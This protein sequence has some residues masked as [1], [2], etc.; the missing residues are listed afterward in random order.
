MG[1]GTWYVQSFSWHYRLFVMLVQRI[2][3][4]FQNTRETISQIAISAE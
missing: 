4:L 1:Q 3:G 2:R